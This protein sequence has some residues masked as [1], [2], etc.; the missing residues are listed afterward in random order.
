MKNNLTKQLIS[1]FVPCY[2]NLFYFNHISAHNLSLSAGPAGPSPKGWL[3][4]SKFL[5]LSWQDMW[6]LLGTSG[7]LRLEEVGCQIICC[8]IV[9]L[10]TKAWREE[11]GIRP[12]EYHIIPTSYV[13]CKAKYI[14][15]WSILQ[16]M[17]DL[18]MESKERKISMLMTRLSVLWFSP[19]C[20]VYR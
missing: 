16:T 12:Q 10:L 20:Y 5:S 14:K 8:M 11:W 15:V 17:G 1:I 13:R 2:F 18:E 6:N 7:S 4:H 19:L 3:V 9:Y